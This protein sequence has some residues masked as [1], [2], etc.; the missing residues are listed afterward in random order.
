MIL[1]R[2]PAVAGAFYPADPATLERDVQAYLDAAEGGAPPRNA[3]LQESPPKAIIVPHAGYVYSGPVA[4]FA[5]ARLTALKGKIERVVLLGPCHRV[6]VMGLA[7]SSADRFATPLGDI[8]IDH[9]LDDD[10]LA[11]P[12][13]SVFDASHAQEHSLEVQLPFLQTVLGSFKLLPM[14][15]GDAT[16]PQVA[17]VL[18][19]VWGGAETLIVISSDLS[20]Y[21]DYNR[22]RAI[23]LQTCRAIE[24]LDG[25]AIGQTQACGRVPVKGLLEVAE[26]KGL[27]VETL[28]LRNSGDTAGSRDRVVGYGAW[29]FWEDTA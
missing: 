27:R 12:Q 8:P 5:Y 18:E 9:A 7:L 29:A 22:A 25:I 4:A 3:P 19:R 10:L 6:A 16:I 26:R 1:T 2:P 21:L 11:L 28:D 20:H 15:V 17:D 23:D 14:V 24:H 13:V